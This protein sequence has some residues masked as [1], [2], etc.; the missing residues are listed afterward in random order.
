MFPHIRHIIHILY[1]SIISFQVMF[2]TATV[3]EALHD[4]KEYGF[5]VVKKNQFDW[6]MLKEKRDA[7]VKR[8]N[9]IYTNNLGKDSITYIQVSQIFIF[10]DWNLFVLIYLLILGWYWF[11]K[12][13]VLMFVTLGHSTGTDRVYPFICRYNS[14]H[15][16]PN[17]SSWSEQPNYLHD[18]W[19]VVDRWW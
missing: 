9:G 17:L 14:M 3:N 19:I 4:A 15:L 18:W 8:L 16:D 2:M 6:A 10:A 1:I 12:M 5:D 13:H 7:Y 11:E